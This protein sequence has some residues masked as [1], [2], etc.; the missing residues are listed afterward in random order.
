MSVSMSK[1]MQHQLQNLQVVSDPLTPPS[2][3][4]MNKKN[5]MTTLV[6]A[7]TLGLGMPILASAT[8]N[9]PP[10]VRA[11]APDIY[12]VKKGDTLWD[13]SGKYLKDAWR[14]KEIW[15]VNPQIR[16]PHWIYPGD[17]LILCSI[18]GHTVVGVDEGD[19]CVGVERRMSSS[20]SSYE[21]NNVVRLS[22]KIHVEPLNAA[23][24]AIPLKD[25]KSWLVDGN[26][27]SEETLSK[28]PYILANNDR[29]V[30]AAAGDSVYVRGGNLVVG[31]SYGVYRQ[32]A[33]FIDPETKEI[34]GTEARLVARGTATALDKDV[35]TL[36]LTETVQQ[37]VRTGDKVMAEE[38]VQDPGIFYPTNAKNV[39]SGRLIRVMDGL[40]QAAIN[41][42]IAVN[43]GER[44]GVH[45][46]QVFAIY[47]RGALVI[48]SHDGK[49]VRLPSERSGLAMVF[50][51]FKKMSYAI[52][53][54]GRGS[55]KVDDEL[56]PP[57]G[58]TE[59]Q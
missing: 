7:M 47:R 15:A 37:E 17:R 9:P 18:Q 20:V 6:L 13:I 40:D 21:S 38:A 16:N 46:G 43:R 24:P 22:P 4:T 57:T 34:L 56:R 55:I 42:T 31:D 36:E 27:V 41:S 39:A 48:D 44:E 19:G 2:E 25:I 3:Q 11:D 30:V 29:H 58:P 28:S 45:P 51:S 26:V 12:I 59:D 49:Q 35:S 8:N 33:P 52:I 5:R 50:R 32:G 23:I 10:A 14:W 1:C 54:E 53:L